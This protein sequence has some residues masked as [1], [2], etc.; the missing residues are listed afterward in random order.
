[1]T[2]AR[3]VVTVNGHRIILTHLDMVMYPETGTTKAEVL[4]YYAH[5]A[6]ALIRHAANRPATRKRWVHGVGTAER[7]GA[8][9]FQKNL[10]E[11]APDWVRRMPIRHTDRVHVYPL[12][13]DLATLTW[14]AQL[15][16]L[17]IHVPQWRFGP[18]GEAAN[19]DRL[20]LDLD[21]GPG[22][23]LTECAE[24][25]RFARPILQGDGT[26]TDT[27]HERQQGHSPLCPS[28]WGL[29][30]RAG[31]PGRARTGASARG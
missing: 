3:Q 2:D 11:G 8:A 12:V 21:P 4:A 31:G 25:A 13:N 10:E 19:P 17:E 22:V 20:V 27:G 18:G 30:G 24:I 9:F 23:G 15:S 16:A 14:L 5:V 28:R 6:P 29:L 7:P 26:G 1:M